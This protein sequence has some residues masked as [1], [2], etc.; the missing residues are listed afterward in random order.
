MSSLV[1][2][3]TSTAIIVLSLCIP[4]TAGETNTVLTSPKTKEKLMT[5]HALKFP[6]TSVMI[7]RRLCTY[8]QGG[9]V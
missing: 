4:T 7:G 9:V 1:L 2:R 5:K 6:P 8:I 3:R